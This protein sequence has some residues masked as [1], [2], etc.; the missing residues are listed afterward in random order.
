M[1]GSLGNL[2]SL[3]KQAQQIGGRLEGLT[4]QLKLLRATGSA[5]GGMVEVEVNG[6]PEVVACRIDPALFE[7]HDRELIEDLVR[8][9]T[10]QAL[11]KSRQLH[12]EA[13]R[14]L[15]GGLELPGLEE[16]LAKLTGGQRP[17]G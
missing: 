1:F 12:A 13:M 14:S 2:G 16:A 11:G 15:A 4:Q 17:D 9:A 5:G 3:L 7:Q 6:L 10:N 8:A